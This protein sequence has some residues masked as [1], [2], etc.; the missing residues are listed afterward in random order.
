MALRHDLSSYA[1]A[2]GPLGP[3][4]SLAAGVATLSERLAADMARRWARGERP[5]AEDFL[6]QH[7][8]LWD[9]PEAAID[10]VYEEICQRREHGEAA[11]ADEVLRR[12]PQWRPQLEVL[13]RCHE[14]LEPGL[15]APA[16]PA[17]GESFA[18]FDLVAEL[19]RGARGRVFL[20]SQPALAGRLVVLKVAPCDGGEHVSLAR[21]Q[22]THIVPLYSVRDDPARN[23]RALCLPYFGG[24]TLA[25]LLQ[26]VAGVPL[27]ERTGRHLLEALDR[28]DTGD[29]GKLPP[30]PGSARQLLDSASYVNALCWVGA[31]LAEALHYAHERGLV[32]LDVKPSNVLLAADAQPML[33]DFHL[34]RAPIPA[35]G[36]PIDW[37]GGTV[38]YMSPEQRL[39]L[40]AVRKGVKVP[41]AVDGRS[42]IYS[43]GLLL[44]EALAGQLPAGPGP[45]PPLNR[46]NRHVS[47]GLADIVAKCLAP[48]AEGR[49]VSA[50]RLAG[51]L[52]AHLRDLPLRGVRNRS[53]LERWHKW[54]R[55]EPLRLMYVAVLFALVSVLVGVGAHFGQKYRAATAALTEGRAQLQKKQYLKA[56]EVLGR[57]R[58][59]VQGLPLSGRLADDLRTTQE[60][61][62]AAALR[63][64]AGPKD[65]VT[66]KAQ[67]LH[68]LMEEI[69]YSYAEAS[70]TGRVLAAVPEP[71]CRAFWEQRVQFLGPAEPELPRHLKQQACDDLLDL[72]ALWTDH[73]ARQSL[74]RASVVT[75]P[76][77][78]A[79]VV[80][81]LCPPP[82]QGPF[83]A[84]FALAPGKPEVAREALGVLAEAEE[85]LGAT[86]FLCRERRR[87]AEAVGNPEAARLAVRRAEQLEAETAWD[88]YALGRSLL[89]DGRSAEAAA[90]LRAAVALDPG[91]FW[92]NFYRGICAERLKRDAEAVAAFSACVGH[93]PDNS[94]C[95]YHR[96]LAYS[97]LKLPELALEDYTQ[98]L[99]LEPSLA[100]ASLNRGLLHFEAGDNGSAI[101]DIKQALTDGIDPTLG[102]YNLALVYAATNDRDSARQCLRKALQHNPYHAPSLDLQRQLRPR[103]Q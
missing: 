17:A 20:A 84:A 82:G 45:V 95:F 18:D 12:F 72:V 74:D 39:A 92:P 27:E 36:P 21:L 19:G 47:V 24:T 66:K 8:D 5:R 52:R 63:H 98:A 75:L 2:R 15:D 60:K 91:A 9:Q 44:Y 69:R 88:H 34:A 51:D 55:R 62:I 41:V 78:G 38:A 79:D 81:S 46:C 48:R 31:A 33:L 64:V 101:D 100:A 96:A 10:L 43:L 65:P 58:S 73:R 102:N 71:E 14:L 53:W 1:T 94:R 76:V 11:A 6:A 85:Q 87:L 103:Q 89:A 7:P 40:E 90:E 61:A 83:L 49:Y 32:H 93:D 54:R 37:I 68:E 99:K 22:H 70:L 35:N 86:H 57:G 16:F 30:C 13:L 3:A 50:A 4:D 80:G 26:D 97:R 25:R 77:L 59:A 29:P 56:A 42:D 23:L 67:E 28:A